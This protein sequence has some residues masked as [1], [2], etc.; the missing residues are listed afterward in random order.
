MITLLSDVVVFVQLRLVQLLPVNLTK[1][2]GSSVSEVHSQVARRGNTNNSCCNVYFC[3]LFCWQDKSL[4]AH[5][6]FIMCV[7]VGSSGK[8]VRGRIPL[9][10]VLSNARSYAWSPVVSRQCRFSY[11]IHKH[12]AYTYTTNN[13]T[14]NLS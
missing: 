8:Q 7:V 12:R 5:D 4:I 11:K 2:G 14:L 6:S 9:P 3:S 1:G 10:P 13:M